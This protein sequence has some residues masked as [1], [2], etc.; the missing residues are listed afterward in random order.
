[1]KKK[2]GSQRPHRR[3]A[4]EDCEQFIEALK[5]LDARLRRVR[6]EKRE[7]DM[8][9][10]ADMWFFSGRDCCGGCRSLSRKAEARVPE[11]A[12]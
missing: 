8:V 12:G 2:A 3:P 7:Q 1:M 5:R 10:E 6:G 4:Q 11:P 9:P